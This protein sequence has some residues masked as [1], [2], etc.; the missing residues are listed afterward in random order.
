MQ[1]VILPGTLEK[2]K[3]RL[4]EL[5]QADASGNR[6]SSRVSIKQAELSRVQREMATVQRN[7]ALASSEDQ[8]RAV[9]VVF[10][11]LK[12]SEA[13][14]QNELAQLQA[15]AQPSYDVDRAVEAA[16]SQLD[17]L[18]E[19]LATADNLQA[20][21]AALQLVNLRVFLKFKKVQAGKRQLNKLAYGAV[22][23]GNDPAPVQLYSG[24]TGRRALMNTAAHNA[25]DPGGNG[26]L[27]VRC[28]SGREGNSLGNANRGDRI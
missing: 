23:F 1:E 25:V 15:T 26:S 10:D 28:S 3:V 20:V 24:P 7:L 11:E 2:L 18:P 8:Y 13:K 5:A 4:C 27:P 16:M 12:A 22:T 9:A 14:L 21:T 17:T 19:L 6:D